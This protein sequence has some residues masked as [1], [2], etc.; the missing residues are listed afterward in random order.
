MPMS[1][2]SRVRLELPVV[3]VRVVV[4]RADEDLSAGVLAGLEESFDVLDGPVLGDAFAD[5]APAT[6]S[7][8]RKSFCGSMTSRA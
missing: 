7:G 2:M 3:V 1:C 5:D 4:V 8:L 6:P